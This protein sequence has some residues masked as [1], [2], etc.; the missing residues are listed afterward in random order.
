V[1][2]KNIF[3]DDSYLQI[4]TKEDTLTV[5][6]SGGYM[7]VKNDSELNKRF[8][9]YFVCE[10]GDSI[11]GHFA[12]AVR[13]NLLYDQP[14]VAQISVGDIDYQIQKGDFV[15]WGKLL[16]NSLYYYEIYFYSTDLRYTDAGKVK[17]GFVLILGMHSTKADFPLNGTYQVSRNY[18]NNTLLWGTKIGSGRWG[19][20][21]NLYRN[22]SSIASSSIHAGNISFERTGD[23]FRIILNLKDQ[24]RNSI[25]NDY[26]L[27]IGEYDYE[28]NIKELF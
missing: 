7:I 24:N 5:A 16:D 23:K 2:E 20:Y 18:E 27:I 15:C 3:L 13:Y 19:T 4:S 12:G 26:N 6:I 22:A 9:F 10:N 21:W 28:L 11:T 1:G 17:S 8:E 25:T 14:A